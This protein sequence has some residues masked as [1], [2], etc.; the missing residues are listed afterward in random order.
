LAI[1]CLFSVLSA[2][3][4]RATAASALDVTELEFNTA[5]SASMPPLSAINCL[6]SVIFAKFL[7]AFAAFS[8]VATAVVLEFKTATRATTIS[9]AFS[10]DRP[11]LHRAAAA[12]LFVASVVVLEFK[13]AMRA[14]IPP[15]SGI[16]C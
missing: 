14:S 4:I 1:N 7:R 9:N 6:F 8:F 13:T 3:V 11:N 12:F 2:K 15:F 16:N 5:T 10:F